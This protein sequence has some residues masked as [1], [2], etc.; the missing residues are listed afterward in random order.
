MI[1]REFLV[2]SS[3]YIIA[4]GSAGHGGA[5]GLYKLIL[6]GDFICCGLQP[7]ISSNKIIEIN[8]MAS[9]NII[10]VQAQTTW[11]SGVQSSS[12]IRDFAPVIMDEPVALGGKDTGANPMEYLVAAL[13]GCKA[14]M[15]PLIAKELAFEFSGLSFDS[16]GSIDLRGLM[17][18]AGISAHF[19]QL[20]F[21]V[22]IS[23]NESEQRVAE[24]QAAVAS[25]CPVYNLLKDAGVQLNTQWIRQ[26]QAI[27][28]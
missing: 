12:Q 6:N 13:N 9:S 15:I 17:G 26:T 21:T 27:A 7:N 24:L 16:K 8:Q 4:R 14:V 19:Q 1:Q 10:T 28:V 25:R 3:I 2:I 11:Q 23:T 5:H 20:D 22:Y 18:V